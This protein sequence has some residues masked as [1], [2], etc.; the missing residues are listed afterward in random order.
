[1]SFSAKASQLHRTLFGRV[2]SFGKD[3][4]GSVAAIV[5]V[6]SPVLVGAMGLGAEAGYWYLTQRQVQNAADVAAHATAIQLNEGALLTDLQELAEYVV[7]EADVNLIQA[8]VQLNQPP[9]EGAFIED[10][11]AIEIVVTQTV[12]RLL[13]AIYSTDPI[14]ITARAVA[15]AQGGGQACVLALANNAGGQGVDIA[16][17]VNLTAINCDVASNVTGSAAIEFHQGTTVTANCLR[18]SGDTTLSGNLVMSCGAAVENASPV[19]DPFISLAEP[20]VTG[21]C[22]GSV[23]EN[24]MVTP[25]FAHP[26]GMM[27]ARFCGGME[28]R[29]NVVLGPGLYIIEGGDLTI[30]AGAMVTG[31]GVIF[32]VAP[33]VQTSFDINATFFISPP[34]TGAYAGVTFF[35]SRSA[36][37]QSHVIAGGF[38]STLDGAI[39]APSSRLEFFGN[40][41]TSF[42]GCTQMIGD[43]VEFKNASIM[44]IHCLFPVGPTASLPGEVTLVE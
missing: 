4:V 6:A 17:N 12:P 43:E 26:S 35:G 31:T 38:G 37:G 22:L 19:A 21:D 8:N 13:S 33:T 28:I 41:S 29:G 18:T 15:T 10:G 42:T 14:V 11:A 30:A 27:S 5:A 20:A 23:V 1:M 16:D 40:F 2:K 9:T 34:T 25:S 32:Y 7:G 24:T 39:Y 3:T 44:Q 36:S